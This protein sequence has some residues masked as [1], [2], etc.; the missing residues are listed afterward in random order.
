MAVLLPP[1]PAC[2]RAAGDDERRAVRVNTTARTRLLP[3]V[4][5]GGGS[6]R[7]TAAHRRLR[8]SR[9]ATVR[10]EIRCDR[11][12]G[13]RGGLHD[14]RPPRRV[15]DLAACD[16]DTPPSG[17]R[18]SAVGRCATRSGTAPAGHGGDHYGA[19]GR[20]AAA[21]ESPP[22][23]TRTTRPVS[24]D[25]GAARTPTDVPAAS[26]PASRSKNS[27]GR[28]PAGLGQP[29]RSTKQWWRAAVWPA[30][31]RRA[32]AAINAVRNALSTA[33][34]FPLR[35]LERQQQA[36]LRILRQRG[37]QR[38]SARRL[39]RARDRPPALAA[40]ERV[41]GEA[42]GDGECAQGEPATTASRRCRRLASS[43]SRAK[44]SSVSCRVRHASTAPASTS[45]KISKRGGPPFRPAADARSA[46]PRAPAT[47]PRGDRCRHRPRRSGRGRRRCA[48]SSTRTA[49]RA[50]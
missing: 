32:R 39:G 2:I 43:R 6:G 16:D 42:G 38:L 44:A 9:D 14:R 28:Y 22:A 48:R 8:G 4:I 20:G 26:R 46:R 11:R 37:E 17:E 19:I 10:S 31:I 35:R 50:G 7:S 45:W 34:A 21:T 30:A 13:S 5:A 12:A 23:A 1:D 47:R 29:I 49:S 24:R 18:A 15:G 41:D 40:G 3:D 33:G 36:Q 25:D 27:G